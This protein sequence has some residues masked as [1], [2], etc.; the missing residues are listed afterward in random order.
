ME[1]T[2]KKIV[3][4]IIAILVVVICVVSSLMF[5]GVMKAPEQLKPLFALSGSEKNIVLTDS[6]G[7]LSTDGT[8]K[9]SDL[10]VGSKAEIYGSGILVLNTPDGNTVLNDVNQGGLNYI[11]GKTLFENDTVSLNGNAMQ[12][13]SLGDGSTYIKYTP[14]VEGP[15]LVGFGGGQLATTKNGWR[16]ALQWSN[17]GTIN[18]PGPSL[19]L[20]NWEFRICKTDG[21]GD[22]NLS[23]LYNGNSVA[24]FGSNSVFSV[25]T[26][27]EDKGRDDWRA[28][29]TKCDKI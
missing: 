4:I 2:S 29:R 17:D 8:G 21:Q 11:K 7:N 16:T 9:I 25:G 26:N 14:N 15:E 10:K 20:G 23:L 18:I 6:N 28:W 12:F 1:I 22:E 5:F 27:V 19:K 3:I 24:K 13:R